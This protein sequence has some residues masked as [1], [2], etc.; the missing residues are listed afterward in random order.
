MRTAVISENISFAD[1]MTTSAADMSSNIGESERS[2]L[3]QMPVMEERKKMDLVFENGYPKLLIEGE[4][5]IEVEIENEFSLMDVIRMKEGEKEYDEVLEANR[6]A[7]EKLIK[8][9]PD[10]AKAFQTKTVKKI[11]CVEDEEFDEEQFF[12]NFLALTTKPIRIPKRKRKQNKEEEDI[13]EKRFSYEIPEEILPIGGRRRGR[14]TRMYRDGKGPKRDHVIVIEFNDGT[15]LYAN[16]LTIDVLKKIAGYDDEQSHIYSQTAGS[17]FVEVDGKPKELTP[18]L[19]FSQAI[20]ELNQQEKQKKQWQPIIRSQNMIATPI[21]TMTSD[22]VT[23]GGSKHRSFLT[24]PNEKYDDIYTKFMRTVKVGQLDSNKFMHWEGVN[25]G[26]NGLKLSNPEGK[27]ISKIF[28]IN[29]SIDDNGD[30]DYDEDEYKLHNTRSYNILDDLFNQLGTDPIANISRHESNFHNSDN[31]Q[32]DFKPSDYYSIDHSLAGYGA[33]QNIP[34]PFNANPNNPNSG[35]V[36]PGFSVSTTTFGDDK[37]KFNIFENQSYVVKDL[38]DTSPSLKVFSEIM[39]DSDNPLLDLIS[40]QEPMTREEIFARHEEGRQKGLEQWRKMDDF[41]A[42]HIDNKFDFSGIGRFQAMDPLNNKFR[43]ASPRPMDALKNITSK[44]DMFNGTTLL[45]VISEV[46][47]SDFSDTDE[48]ESDVPKESPK[49]VNEEPQ[50]E[51]SVVRREPP[52]LTP[53]QAARQEAIKEHL[54]RKDFK[55]LKD[56]LTDVGLLDQ[57]GLVDLPRWQPTVNFMTHHQKATNSSQPI[58]IDLEKWINEGAI[59]SCSSIQSLLDSQLGSAINSQATSQVPS[60]ADFDNAIGES[61]GSTGSKSRLILSETSSDNVNKISNQSSNEE[62]N[63]HPSSNDNSINNILDINKITKEYEIKNLEKL[64]STPRNEDGNI[65]TNQNKNILN[66]LEGNID[67]NHDASNNETNNNIDQN[68]NEN[69]ESQKDNKLTAHETI[70][71]VIQENYEIKSAQEVKDITNNSSD[72]NTAEN[73]ENTEKSLYNNNNERIAIN[74]NNVNNMN[75]PNTNNSKNTNQTEIDNEEEEIEYTEEKEIIDEYGNKKKVTQVVHKKVPRN[76]IQSRKNDSS[77]NG[78]QLNNSNNNTRD[79]NKPISND[80]EDYEKSLFDQID[81]EMENELSQ[82]HLKVNRDTPKKLKRENSSKRTPVSKSNIGSTSDIDS[83][84]TTQQREENERMKMA[85]SIVGVAPHYSKN[86]ETKSPIHIRGNI[87]NKPDDNLVVTGDKKV[88]E[89]K[90]EEKKKK[91]NIIIDKHDVIRNRYQNK[92]KRNLKILKHNSDEKLPIYEEDVRNVDLTK[93]DAIRKSYDNLLLPLNISGNISEFV[94]EEEVEEEEEEEWIFSDDEI[95]EE[96]EVVTETGRVI[97]KKKT[98]RSRRSRPSKEKKPEQKK[99][100]A[101]TKRIMKR[102]PIVINDEEEPT[103]VP[104][105]TKKEEDTPPKI[106]INQISEGKE[107]RASAASKGEL[108]PIKPDPNRPYF[109]GVLKTKQNPSQ[110]PQRTLRTNKG[111]SDTGSKLSRNMSNDSVGQRSHKSIASNGSEKYDLNGMPDII[112]ESEHHSTRSKGKQPWSKRKS[113]SKKDETNKKNLTNTDGKNAKSRKP[114]GLPPTYDAAREFGINKGLTT[115]HADDDDDALLDQLL[116][117]TTAAEPI[118]SLNQLG[119]RDIEVKKTLIRQKTPETR[120]TA[121]GSKVAIFK[122]EDDF[123]SLKLI[124][125]NKATEE[126]ASDLFLSNAKILAEKEF[127]SQTD[128]L[129]KPDTKKKQF[130]MFSKLDISM[131]PQVF[132]SHYCPGIWD[133]KKGKLRRASV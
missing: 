126:V 27:K 114:S 87:R 68:T 14:R 124:P 35:R 29:Q 42:P 62:F 84:L 12:S 55:G 132:F 82:Q 72:K 76:S 13:N 1:S 80:Q 96:E 69:I 105:E 130:F 52:D 3:Y 25:F 85:T 110:R 115:K 4:K 32:D 65:Q 104:P 5:P 118:S 41:D 18:G 26:Q 93:L 119:G 74:Q 71:N 38:I 133:N 125:H 94:E 54:T 31:E 47:F 111:R 48:I 51:F 77:Q 61:D 106:V 123:D 16:K 89:T 30:E 121:L 7:L 45:P 73:I 43:P 6:R 8:E 117:S 98:T 75:L 116:K 11:K 56:L 10:V 90:T 40:N 112:E 122:N 81:K 34:S 78:Q 64:T 9:D 21:I 15:K 88:I 101:R 95:T 100:R 57:Y 66:N 113:L 99:R 46:S 24:R 97:I 70:E 20:A 58:N 22:G 53:A 120:N 109:T 2:S 33:N 91:K 44:M 131:A 19:I 60:F 49:V 36:Q 37:S 63:L 103:S 102:K 67:N 127:G 17:K 86:N 59:K 128:L 28:E 79:L 129:K 50:K 23:I 107:R 39:G 92:M 83:I 108:P